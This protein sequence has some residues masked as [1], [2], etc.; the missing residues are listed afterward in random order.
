MTYVYDFMDST[1]GNW[2]NLGI[3]YFIKDFVK[4]SIPEYLKLSNIINAT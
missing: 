3:N 1:G 2:L 4:W